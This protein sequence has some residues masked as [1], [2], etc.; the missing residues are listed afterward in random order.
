M[1]LAGSLFALGNIICFSA[2]SMGPFL[3]GRA[4]AG[5][6]GAGIL[7]LSSLITTGQSS[8]Y[9]FLRRS[10]TLRM[11]SLAP[12]ISLVFGSEATTKGS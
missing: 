2:L 10:L 11:S 8:T 7:C 1:T 6:G 5:V 4:V 12:Q 9:G 3:W